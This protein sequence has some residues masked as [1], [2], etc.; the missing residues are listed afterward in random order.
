MGYLQSSGRSSADIEWVNDS[1]ANTLSSS[2]NEIDF[3]GSGSIH[4]SGVEYFQSGSAKYRVKV[5]NAYRNIYDNNNITFTTSESATVSSGES[6]SLSN[7]TKPTINTSAGEDHTKSLFITGSSSITANYFIDGAVTAGVNVTHPLKSNLSN[8]GQATVSGIL[9]YDRSNTSTAQNET[10]RRENYRIISGS[11]NTQSSL[12]DGSNVWDSSVH[13]TASNGG[14]SNGLQFYRDRLYSPTQTL[15]SGDFRNTSDGG[16]LDNGPNENPDYSS[17]TGQK[18]F[19]RW[20]KNE[21]GSSKRDLSLVIQGSGTNIVSS[22]TLL[23]SEKIRVFIK[24]PSNGSQSTGWLDISSDFVLGEYGDNS[25]ANASE[26]SSNT[27]NS[28]LN[29]TNEIT[30]GVIEIGDDEYIGLRIEADTSW[31][32]YISNIEVTFGAGAGTITAIPNLDDID[33]NQDGTDA[34]L[35][36]G[37]SKSITGYT[38]VGTTAGF[39]AS[40]LNDFYETSSSSNNLRRSIF[41]LDT[42]IEGNLNEDVSQV[43]N[44]SKINHQANSFSDANSGS[45]KLEV[46]G[47]V[48][49]EVEITGSYNLIGSGDP[50]SGTGTSLNGNGS[51]FINLSVWKPAIYSNG[52]PDYTEIYRTCNYRVHTSDQINGWNYARVIHTIGGADRETNYVEWV[53]DNNA[54]ALSSVGVGLTAFGDDSFSYLS[55]IKYFNSPTGSILARIGNIYKNVYS[56]SSSAISFTSLTNASGTKIIQSGSGLSSTK[57]TVSSTD[58]LQ[59]LNTDTN[60]QNELLHVSGTISFSRSKSLPG[61]YT[62]GYSCAGAMVFDHPL[63]SNLT[64]STQTTTNMLVWTPSDTSNANTNEYF[65]GESYRLVS[66]SYSAQSDITGGSNNWNSQ[67]S[68]NDQAS[69]PEHATGF[70]VYDTY[71]LAPKD[72]GSSGDFRSHDDGGS[73]EGPASKYHKL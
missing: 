47:S 66:S 27:F 15:N 68:V 25:G 26:S 20:F 32:G 22:E 44:G 38:N 61:A 1:D 17:E 2:G 58:S 54:D 70:I 11:Y 45:L 31:A 40:D 65:T 53:N 42:N 67:R 12:V 3:V 36:F 64:L 35:S 51:G 62:T 21:T 8:S 72:G 6:F 9:M 29:A 57:T 14:H 43:T 63:K 16:S 48:V 4:L 34:N 10:F 7:Q 5:D 23:D 55:G 50:G 24:F 69:Y 49:H 33:C 71:L 13:M 73:V 52:V 37:S 39:S 60:S 56:D 18:T 59:T 46:N 30:L 41:A 28:S 19:Y